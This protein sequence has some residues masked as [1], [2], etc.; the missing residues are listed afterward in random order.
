V[1]T[2]GTRE[3]Q[4]PVGAVRFVE[5]SPLII[6]YTG[7]LVSPRGGVRAWCIAGRHARCLPWSINT[8]HRSVDK[9]TAVNLVGLP[10]DFAVETRGA[11]NADD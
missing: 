2:G 7:L 5:R 8:N 9:V 10:A 1:L 6:P 3:L 11:S 4:W